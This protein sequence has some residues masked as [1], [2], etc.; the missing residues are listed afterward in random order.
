MMNI[1]LTLRNQ[2]ISPKSQTFIIHKQKYICVINT[3]FIKYNFT[4]VRIICLSHSE[5][6]TKFIHLFQI[7]SL[8]LTLILVI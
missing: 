2:S 5:E 6:I 4:S 8:I 3:Y 7:D 1:K